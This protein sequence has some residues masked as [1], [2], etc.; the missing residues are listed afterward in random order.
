MIRMFST[1]VRGAIAEA[2]EAAFDQHATRLL[3]QQLRDAATAL[4]LAKKELA[5][6][7][8]HRASEARAVASLDDRIEALEKGAVDALGGGRQD[9]AEEAATV[10]AAV[11]DE[12]K[13]RQ[14]AVDRFDADI[15]RLRR[16]TDEGQRRLRDLG[17]GLELARAREALSRAGANGR[18]ALVSGTGALRE[19]EETL[20][21]IRNN[22]TRQD[23]AEAALEEFER[24]ARATSL[25]ERMAAA[26]FGPAVKSRPADVMARIRSKAGSAAASPAQQSPPASA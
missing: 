24:T 19:A 6:A 25:D 8:A 22:Q 17:R 1:L 26:G 20:A 18:Q 15:N 13:E 16:L 4:E 14:A 10:I 12:R 7:V 5:C 9:L 21:R 2:E 11:E 3:A 23:D